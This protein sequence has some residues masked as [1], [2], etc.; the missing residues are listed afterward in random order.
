M[1]FLDSSIIA[2]LMGPNE[3]VRAFLS[4]REP[5]WTS[6]ICVFEVVQGR[7]GMGQTDVQAVRQE[8][9]GVQVLDLNET[10]ALEA[11]RLQD[12]LMGAGDRLATVDIL[13]AATA[14]STG[15]ELV[16]AD[17]DFETDMLEDVMRVHNLETQ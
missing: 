15:E 13:I 16:V 6:S 11:A 8:F 14:R 17:A 1:A 9:P 2:E 4:G 3:T 10:I 5:F 7:L 12:R